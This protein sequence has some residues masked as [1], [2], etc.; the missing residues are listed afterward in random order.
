MF[1][2]NLLAQIRHQ[3]LPEEATSRKQQK[4]SKILS[5][6]I[7]RNVDFYTNPS[8][9]GYAS[10]VGSNCERNFNAASVAAN[11]IEVYKQLCFF[12]RLT[13]VSKQTFNKKT[14]Y[15]KRTNKNC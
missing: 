12:N 7:D 13:L 11:R 3:K 1:G 14:H 10:F 2:R 4:H 9:Y 6:L 15:L 8:T 5:R